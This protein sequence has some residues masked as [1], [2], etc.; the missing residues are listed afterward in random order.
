MAIKKADIHCHILPGIDDGAKNTE[1]SLELLREHRNQGVEKVIFTPHFNSDKISVEEFSAK[2]AQSAELLTSMKEFKDIGIE[3]KLGA[4]IYYTINL[5]ELDL[6]NLCFSGSDYVLVELPTQARPHGMKRTFGNMIR[7]GYIPIIAH[8]E[9]YSYM[10]KN[11]NELYDLIDL[12][13]L[14]HINA[15]ALI[16]KT[17]ATSMI[18][19]FV[20]HGLVHFMC[21]DCHSRHRRPPNLKQGFEEMRSLLGDKYADRFLSN[22]NDVFNAQTINPEINNLKKTKNM[23]GVWI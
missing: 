7:N 2:R 15:E 22:A 21:S 3:Y 12:G 6:S 14:A 8:V 11:P 10:L 13:C 1:V 5:G 9:R 18:C 19:Y 23:F 16:Q 4:E 20:R 17:K